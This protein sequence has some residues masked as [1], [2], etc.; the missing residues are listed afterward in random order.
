[1]PLIAMTREMRSLGKGVCAPVD[2]RVQRVME[3]LNTD[4]EDYLKTSAGS[5]FK[6]DY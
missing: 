4:D 1:M 6:D 2:V 3:R 5:R